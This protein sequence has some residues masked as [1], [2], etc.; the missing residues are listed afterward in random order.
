MRH[1]VGLDLLKE[2]DDLRDRIAKLQD[3]VYA[4][5]MEL[6][7]ANKKSWWRRLWGE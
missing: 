7:R 6:A 2:N 4:L 5:E 3:K 1:I